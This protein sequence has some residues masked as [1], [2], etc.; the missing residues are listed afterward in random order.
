M[1]HQ[2]TLVTSE[3]VSHLPASVKIVWLITGLS[4]FT[5]FV[6]WKGYDTVSD[7]CFFSHGLFISGSF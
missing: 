6:A 5:Y 2:A 7:V 3:H 1:L 4:T